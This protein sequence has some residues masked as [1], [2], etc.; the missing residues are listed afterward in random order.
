[1]KLLINFIELREDGLNIQINME[2]FNALLLG[3]GA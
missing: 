1:M 3:L 2:G